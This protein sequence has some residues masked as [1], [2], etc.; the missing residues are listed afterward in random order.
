MRVAIQYRDGNYTLYDPSTS[1][2]SEGVDPAEWIKANTV[3]ISDR[4]WKKYLKHQEEDRVWQEHI[5][6]LDEEK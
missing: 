1:K 5:R 6:I 4:M 2:F 3:E